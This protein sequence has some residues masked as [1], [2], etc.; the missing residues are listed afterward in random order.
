[1]KIYLIKLNELEDEILKKEN[2]Y[3]KY[4]NLSEN[5]LKDKNSLSFLKKILEEIKNNFPDTD[6]LGIPLIN[7]TFDT[8]E[9]FKKK[10][11][12]I[13]II[14]AICDSLKE[15]Y[16]N[17]YNLEL[18]QKLK[19]TK[20]YEE[21]NFNIKKILLTEDQLIIDKFNK[22]VL[23]RQNKLFTTEIY[24]IISNFIT[25]FLLNLKYK[26][27]KCKIVSLNIPEKYLKEDINLI[28]ENIKLL[29]KIEISF[30]KN[31]YF[32]Y[33]NIFNL[34][35]SL[36]EKKEFFCSKI[37]LKKYV[38]NN[39]F[40]INT[41]TIDK[42]KEY[43]HKFVEK[44]SKIKV[45]K[46]LKE[47]E[48]IEDIIGI[49]IFDWNLINSLDSAIFYNLFNL[50]YLYSSPII[51]LQNIDTIYKMI[52]NN[53]IEFLISSL[54]YMKK[55]ESLYL[56][57][58]FPWINK[59]LT[60]D[61]SIIDELKKQILKLEN[62]KNKNYFNRIKEQYNLPINIYSLEELKDILFLINLNSNNIIF[63]KLK[64]I[65]CSLAE[66]FI[67]NELITNYIKE[68]YDKVFIY[69]SKDNLNLIEDK[70][71]II[72]NEGI[73]VFAVPESFLRNDEYK[74]IRI[75]FFKK[76]RI[77]TIIRLQKYDSQL[78]FKLFENYYLILCKGIQNE[79]KFIDQKN[80]EIDINNLVLL[81]F[82]KVDQLKNDFNFQKKCQS[83]TISELEK[84]NLEEIPFS[85]A[86]DLGLENILK[87]IKEL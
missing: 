20:S 35:E 64:V 50:I 28:I 23:E 65:G 11:I 29:Y 27:K 68:K 49:S 26:N 36:K 52:P 12:F 69:F 5:L 3:L 2:I 13:T 59:I 46:I 67:E 4:K 74:K 73:G 79:I 10:L 56:E 58:N 8:E 81:S 24:E 86:E 82:K 43:E 76:K 30:K 40:E 62:V 41:L 34:K 47:M 45:S 22:D 72:E 54:L 1:M 19:K 84:M 32:L 75:S 44:I 15:N 48:Y 33:S 78:K 80:L 61:F 77:N 51:E 57:A 7:F 60:M 37:N 6:F 71:S 25:S 83:I 53:N 18:E 66:Y 14:F 42:K 31:N 38:D 17:I 63:D 85:Y 87:K 16:S 39:Y 55:N 70:L 21:L 9:E